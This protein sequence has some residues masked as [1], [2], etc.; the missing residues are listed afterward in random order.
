MLAAPEL[1][2]VLITLPMSLH[3]EWIVKAAQA[4]KHVLC[5]KPMVLTV[6]EA[7]Q[8]LDAARTN[9]THPTRN[10]GVVSSSSGSQSR[11]SGSAT[12]HYARDRS[13]MRITCTSLRASRTSIRTRSNTRKT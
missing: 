2:V 12:R 13:E 3:C 6:E 8:V 10:P 4:G 5:E 1:D 9:N 7:E 11:G